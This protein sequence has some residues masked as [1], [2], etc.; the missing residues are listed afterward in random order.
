MSCV[1]VVGVQWGDEGKGKIIDWL[2]SKVDIVA[3]FHGGS[4]AGHTIVIGDS[5]VKLSIL[6]SSVLRDGKVAVIG[7]GVVLDLF[8]LIEELDI[9]KSLGRS[10]N[11][12]DLI[13]SDN[14]HVIL[15]IHRTV[16]TLRESMFGDKKIGTTG[17]GIGP[18][19]EDK[20]GRRGIRVCDLFES[21]PDILSEKLQRLVS[22]HNIF[23][24]SIG[25][26]EVK[27]E[28]LLKE[29]S[30]V[31]S[32]VEKYVKC[33]WKYM[34]D[35]I[36]SGRHIIFEGAQ[37]VMLDV[38]H[39]TYPFVT[40]SNSLPACAFIGTGMSF[41]SFSDILGVVKAYSTRVGNG[42]FPT[43]LSDDIGLEICKRG[44]EVGTVSGRVRRCGWFDAVAVRQA[45]RIS[46]VSCL[47]MT[48]I[49]VLD[50]SD[51]IKVC[52]AYEYG[53]K[54]YDYLPSSAE[55]QK[56]LKP[57]YEI[58]DGWKYSTSGVRNICDLDASALEYVRVIEKL[59]GVPIKLL[60]TGPERDEIVVMDD[61]LL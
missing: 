22:H 13:I 29:I 35:A 34:C 31:L 55:L 45:V 7:N 37:G 56:C 20:V 27:K 57:V 46:G 11:E 33:G 17:K 36:D 59:I 14:A 1:S 54:T 8:R 3:R 24:K 32:R 26:E 40:S 12:G 58:F 60:S 38:D 53:G 2:S 23:L 9:L 28:T 16:D 44:A 10:L 47:A 18:C 43:E 41:R 52:V 61:I 5:M 49:D 48:K 50:F 39:G 6:P 51:K 19:Y 30:S 25:V 15:S 21:N 42:P 4:N